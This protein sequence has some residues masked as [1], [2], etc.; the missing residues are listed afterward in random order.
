MTVN[1][2]MYRLPPL[3]EDDVILLNGVL[4]H[5]GCCQHLLSMLLGVGLDTMNLC[6]MG[7]PPIKES[8]R[9]T[10]NVFRSPSLPGIQASLSWV[11]NKAQWWY[12]A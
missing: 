7:S 3:G 11:G 2:V 9:R 5:V 6:R 12:R 10:S 1:M 4:D 8:V